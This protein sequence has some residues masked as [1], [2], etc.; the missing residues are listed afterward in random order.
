MKFLPHQGPGSP[1]PTPQVYS[2]V[3]R[4]I[5]FCRQDGRTGP[6]GL[7]LQADEQTP[8]CFCMMADNHMTISD[9]QLDSLVDPS[10]L[11]VHINKVL[12]D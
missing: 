3:Q 6:D 5:A 4:F 12:K 9:I 1:P 8:M 10:C 7:P 2:S 11:K